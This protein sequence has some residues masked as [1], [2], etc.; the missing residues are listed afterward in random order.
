MKEKEILSQTEIDTLLTAL[1]SG[2]AK[3]EGLRDIEKKVSY[4][5]Y[6]FRR[7]DKF[8]KEQLRTLS[9][10]HDNFARLLSS[11]I[12]AYLRFN[13]N[14]RVASVEQFTFDDFIRSIPTPTILNVFS[15]KP[16]KGLAIMETNSQFLFPVI[17][18]MFGGS[19]EM[20][21]HV[22]DLTEIEMSVV[23]QLN[24]QIL[25]YLKLAW[26][27][28][29]NIEPQLE[30][31]EANPRLYQVVSPSEIVAV[32]TLTTVVGTTRGLINICFPYLMLEPVLSQIS[33]YYT[34]SQTTEAT[35][36]INNIQYWLGDAEVELNVVLGEANIMVK[37]F[38]A[39]TRGDVLPLD[40]KTDQE[41]DLYIG[42]QLK[43]K[44]QAGFSKRNLA[45]QV[46]ALY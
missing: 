21:S 25:E 7:P 18:L 41:L 38:L 33:T 20:P 32:I 34:F 11:F 26:T 35:E 8:S 3:V 14:V 23:R 40:R 9:T 46:N 19:G 37:D 30:A 42:D 5:I 12:S 44:V 17:D 10:L 43:F 39:L 45:V 13:C 1:S 36:E 24:I 15:A 6:N 16:C 2:K 22:R 28:I 4:K 29:F 27:D 31:I